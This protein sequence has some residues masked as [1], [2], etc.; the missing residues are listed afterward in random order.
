GPCHDACRVAVVVASWTNSG[1]I[2]LR[3]PS[4]ERGAPCLIS[5]LAQDP[6]RV[7]RL[8]AVSI[9][10]W[11]GVKGAQIGV[12]DRSETGR[13]CISLVLAIAITQVI[14]GGLVQRGAY[15]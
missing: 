8:P 15:C 9:L 6:W 12:V 1:I 10:R 7:T 4:R 11:A 13:V 3:I 2:L 14:A 5:L